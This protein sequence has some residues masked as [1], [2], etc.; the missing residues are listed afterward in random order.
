MFEHKIDLFG[1]YFFGRHDEIALVLAV[2]VIDN[3]QKFA[4][5]KIVDSRLNV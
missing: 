3:N 2:F 4:L 1:R 5:A